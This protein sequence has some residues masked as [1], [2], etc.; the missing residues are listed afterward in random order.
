MAKPPLKEL[1]RPPVGAHVAAILYGDMGHEQKITGKLAPLQ[2]ALAASGQ[3]LQRLIRK[4]KAEN[5][6][7]PG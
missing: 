6:K 4:S 1:S 7:A 2:Q 3:A 5:P